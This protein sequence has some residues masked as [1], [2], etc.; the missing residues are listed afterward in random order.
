MIVAGRALAASLLVDG[1]TTVATQDGTTQIVVAALGAAGVCGAAFFAG[2]RG[3]EGGPSRREITRLRKER[4][5]ALAERDET[6]ELNER[7][8]DR[9]LHGDGP[10]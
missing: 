2:W 5:E 10:K 7:L 6:R 1:V 9:M 8:L 4:D 3:R